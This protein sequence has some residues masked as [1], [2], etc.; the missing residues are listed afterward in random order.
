MHVNTHVH[1]HVLLNCTSGTAACKLFTRR[2]VVA[3]YLKGAVLACSAHALQPWVEVHAQLFR[4]PDKEFTD[5][6]LSVDEMLGRARD[7]RS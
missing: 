5:S 2:I 3:L 7:R 6:A 1:A 4:C